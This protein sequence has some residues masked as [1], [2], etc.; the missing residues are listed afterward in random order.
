MQP[1]CPHRSR[2]RDTA[3]VL[4]RCSIPRFAPPS[5]VHFMALYTQGGA[6]QGCSAIVSVHREGRG[7]INIVPERPLLKI[8]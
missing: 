4:W 2:L 5:L 7:A 1:C 6:Y 3:L 8:Y